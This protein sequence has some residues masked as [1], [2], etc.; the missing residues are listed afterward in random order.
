MDNIDF[1][2]LS[3]NLVLDS[4]YS[5]INLTHLDLFHEIQ[6]ILRR[7]RGHGSFTIYSLDNGLSIRCFE[8]KEG[9]P[10]SL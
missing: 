7:W 4:R 9:V 8:R 3:F 2:L 6:N 5:S 1:L 10:K